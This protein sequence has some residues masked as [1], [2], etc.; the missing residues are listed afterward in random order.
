MPSAVMVD[1]KI[2]RGPTD[3]GEADLGGTKA[4]GMDTMM[5]NTP[6]KNVIGGID[7]S[8]RIDKKKN[9]VARHCLFSVM[10]GSGCWSV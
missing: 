1:A 3:I 5:T 6:V 4:M 9:K 7:K 10:T 8:V 2:D